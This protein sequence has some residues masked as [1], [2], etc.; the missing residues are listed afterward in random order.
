MNDFGGKQFGWIAPQYDALTSS[1][2][3]V[4]VA[5]GGNDAGLVAAA[6]SCVNAFPEPF[7]SS[8]KDRYTAGGHDQIAEQIDAVGPSVG[9][10]LDEV[11]RRSP[12]ATVLVTGYG[13]YVQPGGC[14]PLVPAWPRDADYIQASV[15]HLNAMLATQAAAHGASY[16]DLR[17]PSIGHDSCADSSTRWLEGLFPGSAA[18]PLHPSELGMANF[19]RLVAAAAAGG[20][21]F[22]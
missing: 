13:T 18:A 8:C 7:G 11:H 2:D 3:L 1:T 20:N 21:T 19:G 6:L 17:T 9:K 10:A 4:T 14:Y 16:V 5:I 15:D 12:H 22:G